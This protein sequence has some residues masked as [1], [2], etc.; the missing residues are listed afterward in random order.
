MI[1]FGY[2]ENKQGFILKNPNIQIFKKIKLRKSFFIYS[3]KF[4]LFLFSF[5]SLILLKN[6]YSIIIQEFGSKSYLWAFN[7]LSIGI[8]ENQFKNELCNLILKT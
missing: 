6:L 3:E 4:R 8:V 5:L 1:G 7:P 2:R